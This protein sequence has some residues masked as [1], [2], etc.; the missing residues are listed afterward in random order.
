MKKILAFLAM[1][2]L[3]AGPARAQNQKA[4]IA[5]VGKKLGLVVESDESPSQTV[6]VRFTNFTAK[7]KRPRA[8]VVS[9]N[10]YKF[11]ESE[12]IAVSTE[13][14][15]VTLTGGEIQIR[16]VTRIVADPKKSTITFFGRKGL[17]WEFSPDGGVKTDKDGGLVTLY[18]YFEPMVNK[19]G[20]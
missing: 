5:A 12:T 3:A 6:A 16:D 4:Q 14:P 10:S 19:K 13:D 9:K 7:K 8:R 20:Q 15:S 18:D 17:L 2:S 11:G 1:A